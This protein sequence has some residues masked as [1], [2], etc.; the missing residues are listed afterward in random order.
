MISESENEVLRE[1]IARRLRFSPANQLTK[2]N[3][4]ASTAITEAALRAALAR[5]QDPE[6]GRSITQL[7]QVHQLLLED[8]RASITLG[9][10]TW[11]APLWEETAVELESSLKNQ[12]PGL[13]VSVAVVE[14]RRPPEKMGQ[15]GLAVKSL[16][17]VGAGKGGVGKS[18]VAV[19]LAASLARSGCKV[20]LLDANVYGPSV[21]HL[22]GAKISRRWSMTRSS[23]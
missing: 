18:S 3:H 13:Q 21:P 4:M 14:H 8:G 15:V 5:F 22:L 2:F 19:L 20:G 9:L 1:E 23:R 7:N 10:T 12:F 11:V 17:A 16:I 6:T